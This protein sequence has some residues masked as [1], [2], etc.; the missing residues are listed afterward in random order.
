MP[1]F[2]WLATDHRFTSAFPV[3]NQLRRIPVA[4]TW[5]THFPAKL[6]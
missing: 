5:K 4:F 2:G 6:T 1:P 3:A